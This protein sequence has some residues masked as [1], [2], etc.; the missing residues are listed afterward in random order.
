MN[1]RGTTH[2]TLSKHILLP[3]LTAFTFVSNSVQAQNLFAPVDQSRGCY[4]L[5]DCGCGTCEH[6][7]SQALPY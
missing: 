4:E 5:N 1:R 3:L 2:E 7:Y 6:D